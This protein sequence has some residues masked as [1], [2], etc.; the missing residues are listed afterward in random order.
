MNNKKAKHLRR[1]ARDSG[2]T[3]KL[4]KKSYKNLR[5]GSKNTQTES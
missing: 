3:Y 5:D 2:L 4:I 1:L